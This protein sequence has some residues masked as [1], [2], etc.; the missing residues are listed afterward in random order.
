MTF[1]VGDKVKFNPHM[2][3]NQPYVTSKRIS[4]DIEYEVYK[5]VRTL[6]FIQHQGEPVSRVPTAGADIGWSFDRFI[7]V[8]GKK[9]TL[10]KKVV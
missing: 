6:V 7:L 3:V 5:I 10:V 9:R 2:V 4:Y 8:N 1:K